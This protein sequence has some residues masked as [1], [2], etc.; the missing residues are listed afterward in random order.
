MGG[1]E[2]ETGPLAIRYL[3]TVLMVDVMVDVS[4]MRPTSSNLQYHSV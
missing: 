1:K 4:L 3:E 2:E